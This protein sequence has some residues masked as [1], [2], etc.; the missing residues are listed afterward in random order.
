MNSGIPTSS[1]R[2]LLECYI[3]AKDQ[4][5]PE[6]IFD[7]FAADAELTF[8]I[9]TEAIDF[10]RSVKG[11][12][13]IAKTLVA[14]FGER[15]DCC[16]TYYVCAAPDVDVD[17]VCAMPWLVA[18]RQKDNGALRLGQGAYRWRIAGMGDGSERIVGLHIT[19]ESMDTID[20]PGS[21]R[22]RSLQDTLSYP[23]LMPAEL[24]PRMD[25]FMSAVRAN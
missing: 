8:D 10:P 22:L 21:A 14:D 13:A 24:A 25:A 19:I 3:R 7:C 11:A 9:A 4:N 6:L 17:G 15:F 2:S 5:Q 1:V 12:A 23:W 16:R 18:M 20:D